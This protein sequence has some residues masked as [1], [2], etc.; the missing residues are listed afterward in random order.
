MLQRATIVVFSG[1]VA[2][3]SDKLSNDFSKLY[4]EKTNISRLYLWYI[5]FVN[6]IYFREVTPQEQGIELYTKLQDQMRIGRDVEDLGKELGEL[7][8]F[9]E[10]IQ[11]GQLTL[12][13]GRFVPHFCGF[14]SSHIRGEY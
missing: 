12:I 4:N 9:V 1:E 6:R 10:T 7:N 11:Q 2:R 5:K 14:S 3:I 13:A 8:E